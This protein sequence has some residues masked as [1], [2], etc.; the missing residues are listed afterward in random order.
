VTLANIGWVYSELGQK[1]K[2]LEYY[3][4]ALPIHREVGDRLSEGSTLFH[5]G[6]LLDNE[7]K[8]ET[9]IRDE[10][11]ALKL[12]T[13]VGDPDLQGRIEDLLM[14]VFRKSKRPELAILFGKQAVNSYQ[15][16]RKN[17]TGLDKELQAGFAESKS[18]TYRML[19]ALLV[20]QDRLGE[21]EQVLDLLKQEELKETVRGAPNDTGTKMQ[22][23]ALSQAQQQAVEKLP[24]PE[25][26]AGGLVA[27][28]V[29]YD[30][31]AAKASLTPTEKHRFQ[32]LKAR[33]EAGQD[34]LW[35]FLAGTL[36]SELRVK[37]KDANPQVNTEKAEERNL[38]NAIR[39]MGPGVV[40]VRTL[41]GDETYVIVVTANG[42]AKHKV[43]I[44]SEKLKPKVLAVR[45]ELRSPKSDPQAHLQELYE[46]LVA[47]MEDDLRGAH[48]ILWSL[49]GVLR[50][51]PMAALY[52]GKQY[53]V[54]RFANVE[55]TPESY[56]HLG[57][58]REKTPMNALAMGLAKSYGGLPELTR[59][60]GEL[61]AIV[62]D[63]LVKESHGPLP[64]TLL[65]DADFT[66]AALEQRLQQNYAV[67]HIA[68]HFEM[69]TG[70]GTEPYLLLSDGR[71]TLSDLEVSTMNFSKTRLLTLSAC[72]TGTLGVASDGREVESLGMV[73][74][75]K[76]AAAVLVT[77]WN[78]SDRST[79][80]LMSDFYTL[81]TRR[82]DT[83]KSDA[84]Q[85]AQMAMLRGSTA[86]QSE[87]RVTSVY[88]HPYYWAP[89]VLIGNYQ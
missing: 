33:M 23:V 87:A 53:L 35:K 60:T 73:A 17:I 61:D 83:T 6:Y 32:E 54:E 59:V 85:Q 80:R 52:D 57:L 10:F 27:M 62:R 82:S 58:A 24:K 43:K 67:V 89:F 38:Q 75:G 70:E 56:L 15:Q 69:L 39:K 49:D 46:L 3:G 51:L 34:E 1:Q 20:T 5:M 45:E 55:V 25:A 37:T 29:E 72:S 19:A 16:I 84:L 71:L 68:S 76:D 22:P 26:L 78:V 13:D 74:Q 47:P 50:Y 63:P 81:L 11:A 18:G 9:A 4:H 48:T 88:A 21:A 14:Q 42:Y 66:R 36:Y 12:A 2:A 28:S 79:S 31:L 30:G 8:M 44:P 41:V 40:G 86:A 7:G 64:G 65:L 77:L